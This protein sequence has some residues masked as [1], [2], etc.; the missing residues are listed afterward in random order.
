MDAISIHPYD[1]FVVVLLALT[2]LFGA[3]KGVVWQ[4]ASIASLIVSYVVALNYSAQLAPHISTQAPWNRFVAMLILYVA[5]AI[6]IWLLFGAVA[7]FIEQVRLREFDRQ[8]GALF[9]LA[10]GVL[11]ALA[12][13]FFMVTLSEQGRRSVLESRSGYLMARL[14]RRAEPI[15]P[16]E[17]DEVLGQYLDRLQQ[18]LEPAAPS[19]PDDE[20]AMPPAV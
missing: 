16:P 14:I 20:P 11:L 9:G 2:T 15:I 6:A 1:V 5:T 18:E 8:M 4:I 12:V 19:A 13:T 17:V 3:W 7:R 10:T